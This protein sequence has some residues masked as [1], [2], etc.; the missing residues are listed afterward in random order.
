[1]PPKAIEL[2]NSEVEK[3]KNKGPR[4]TRS[5]P[6]LILTPANTFQVGKRAAEH[7]ITAWLRS[8]ICRVV[9][10]FSM[11]YG[12]CFPRYFH[13]ENFTIRQIFFC[14]C[15]HA[16]N[17]PNFPAA[18]VS[19]HTVVH[20]HDMPI[21]QSF[22]SYRY[23]SNCYLSNYYTT[24]TGLILIKLIQSDITDFNISEIPL[25]VIK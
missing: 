10:T 6:Y 23:P 21:L 12:I 18:K 7:G 11:F 22:L 25:E 16:M 5:E 14:Q 8:Q 3:V 17:S 9:K 13:L 4:G 20:S 19:L 24:L 1:M 2:A 15:V